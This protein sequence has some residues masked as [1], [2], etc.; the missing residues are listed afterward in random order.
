MKILISL[1]YIIYFFLFTFSFSHSQTPTQYDS[2]IYAGVDAIFKEHYDESD[3]LISFFLEQYPDNPV[4]YFYRGVM[5]WKKSTGME[6]FRKYDRVTI[7]WLEK[8]IDKSDDILDRDE[9]NVEAL[10]YRGGSYG[11]KAW[12]YARQKKKLKTGYNALKGIRN[13]E[14]ARKKNTGLYDVYFGTGLY[15]VT[16]ANF[17]GIV[18]FISRLL[19]IP[20]GDHEQGM[21]ELQTAHEKG[22]LAKTISLYVIAYSHFYYEKDNEAAIQKIESIID[23]YPLCVDLQLLLI[24]AYFYRE[25]TNPAGEW[26]T[27]I[28]LILNFSDDVKSRK[29]NLSS[30]YTN[31]LK[32]MLGYCY[33]FLQDYEKAKVLLE[34]YSGAYTKKG[35]SYFAGVSE[36]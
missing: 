14:K 21:K 29:L 30:W 3:S 34:Q 33:Y 7:E 23:E 20:P 36:C 9:N 4:G 22:F 17:K 10:F 15:N 27:V 13:L 31:K 16:A 18:K 28:N 24:N 12:V 1:F 8:A 32:F 11:F 19:F 2:V 26:N 5:E 6:D 35:A 25:L